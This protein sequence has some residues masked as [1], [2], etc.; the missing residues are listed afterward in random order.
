V[1]HDDDTANVA[2]IDRC[3]VPGCSRLARGIFC[4]QHRRELATLA[5]REH[6]E[7]REHDRDDDWH[8][9]EVTR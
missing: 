9:D 7:P 6:R 4:R 8:L 3:A 2:R 1:R 5:E